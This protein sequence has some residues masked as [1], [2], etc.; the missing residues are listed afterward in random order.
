MREILFR[1]KNIYTGE[2]V[3]GEYTWKN[4]SNPVICYKGKSQKENNEIEYFIEVDEKTFGQY[5][6]LK[7]RYDKPIY[8]GDIVQ[9]VS[10]NEFFTN[11]VGEPLEALQRKMVIVFYQG[12]FCMLEKHP[13]DVN[14]TYWDLRS[15]SQFSVSGDLEVIGNIYDNPELIEEK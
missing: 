6:G 1:G 15:N 13:F 4:N 9:S 8:E 12:A 10:W 3:I 11:G 14:V 5:T 2:W 7:D